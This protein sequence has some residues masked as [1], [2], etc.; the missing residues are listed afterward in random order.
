M[1]VR[2]LSFEDLIAPV[3]VREFMTKHWEKSFLHLE[4][5]RD[6]Y[7]DDLFSMSDIDRW[8]ASTRSGHAESI[9]ITP[10]MGADGTRGPAKSYEPREVLIEEVSNAFVKGH[11]VVLNR[12]ED[13]WPAVSPLVHMFGAVFCA[14]VGVNAYL[15]PKGSQ[16]FPLHTDN[17]EVFVLQ[18]HGEKVWRLKALTQLPIMRLSYAK[19][20]S[21][22]PGWG[23]GDFEGQVI[24]EPHLRP[25]DVLYV[26][27]G[28]PHC[29]VT[30]DKT[31]LHLTVSVTTLYWVDFLK[32]AAEQTAL[33]T[34]LLR[35]SLPPGFA[36]ELGAPEAMGHEFGEVL[37]AF[38]ERVSFAEAFE[39]ARN[40]RFRSQGFPPDGHFAHLTG[41]QS[42]SVS[43]EVERR[44]HVLCR[45]ESS[46]DGRSTIRFGSR[47]VSG[48][49]HLLR[50]M[51]L[52]RDRECFKIGDLPGL[53]DQSRI[54]LTRRLIREGLLR[55]ARSQGRP[56]GVQAMAETV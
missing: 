55:L 9:V 1:P 45:V 40:N 37:K 35:K 29:A 42:L 39:A 30:Q 43:T 4:R 17:H 21:Y 25:G 32:M 12:L 14:D 16:T 44:E 47:N 18:I 7:F 20:L 22:P 50:A 56:A 52:I 51:E 36:T 28:M 27:R 2:G 24:A 34:P 19:D 3:S 26:P 10:P 48:P 11:S 38:N 49:A 8:L 31:S 33:Q 23:G 53:D 54:V 41:L 6:E 46:A 15:T 13:S 5:D